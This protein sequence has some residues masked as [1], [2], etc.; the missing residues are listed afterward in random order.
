MPLCLRLCLSRN[1]QDAMMHPLLHH[2]NCPSAY[3]RVTS[4]S[5]TA[6]GM[7]RTKSN[8]NSKRFCGGNHTLG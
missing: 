4:P 6:P 8:L 3:T 2:F 7:L 5:T 1:S